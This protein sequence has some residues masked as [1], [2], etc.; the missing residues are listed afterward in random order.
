MMK[1]WHKVVVGVGESKW[2][3]EEENKDMK[4]HFILT[5]R[6]AMIF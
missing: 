1:T 5:E 3:Y 6:M 4:E 2:I